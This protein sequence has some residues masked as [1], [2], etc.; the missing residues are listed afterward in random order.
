MFELGLNILQACRTNNMSQLIFHV[1]TTLCFYALLTLVYTNDIS[2]K[3]KHECYSED[4]KNKKE[5]MFLWIC[6][7]SIFA[8]IWSLLLMLMLML[9]S[10]TSLHFFISS[11]ALACAYACVATENQALIIKSLQEE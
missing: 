3:T 10:H 4:F 6:F 1:Q 7:C 9:M 5:R 2:K 8:Y 11:F